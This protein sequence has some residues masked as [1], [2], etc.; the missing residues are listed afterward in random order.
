M[1]KAPVLLVEDDA[2]TAATL[3]LYLARAGYAVEHV[4]DGADAS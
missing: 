1:P 2:K 3:R 4:A